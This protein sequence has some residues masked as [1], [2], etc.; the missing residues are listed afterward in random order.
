MKKSV[1]TLVIS[2]EGAF[3]FD[4]ALAA[5]AAT[6][7]DYQQLLLLRA[8]GAMAQEHFDRLERERRKE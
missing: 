6:L 1:V 3:D 2:Y 7:R 5:A 8:A 4:V